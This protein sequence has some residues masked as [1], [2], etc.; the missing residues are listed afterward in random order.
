[1][2][3]F[4]TTEQKRMFFLPL[5]KSTCSLGHTILHNVCQSTWRA[6]AHMRYSSE[7]Q[8]KADSYHPSSVSLHPLAVGYLKEI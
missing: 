2:E 6:V 5:R 3:S 4:A 7:D 1:M 8:Q